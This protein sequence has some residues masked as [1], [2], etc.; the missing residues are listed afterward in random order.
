MIFDRLAMV[1]ERHL[2][3]LKPLLEQTHLFLFEG[4][5]HEVLP[6]EHDQE[7]IDFLAENFFLPFPVVAIEDSA[8][9]IILADTI[10]HQKGLSSR[11]N[12]IEVMPLDGSTMGEFANSAEITE[13]EKDTKWLPKGYVTITLGYIEQVSAQDGKSTSM[14]VSLDAVFGAD[15]DNLRHI[16]PLMST[17]DVNVATQETGRNIHTAYEEVMFFNTPNRFVVERTALN[18]K[19]A[20]KGRVQRAHAREN[21]ILLTPDEIRKTLGV[22]KESGTGKKVRVHERRRHY[23]KLTSDHFKNKKGQTIVIPATW[24]GTSETTVGKTRYKVC[25][26][27]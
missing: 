11:R 22:S 14:S 8:S 26:D 24:C 21:Y 6:K 20:A 13:R 10:P 4:R 18:T 27:I 3:H 1:A 16:T 9:C 2:P 19:R 15:K 23:R 12:F 25:L 5:A 17:E 7:T